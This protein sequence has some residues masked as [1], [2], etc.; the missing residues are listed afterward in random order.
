M[1][2]SLINVSDNYNELSFNIIKNLYN[3]K[4]IIII[5]DDNDIDIYRYQLLIHSC[6]FS[7]NNLYNIINEYQYNNILICICNININNLIELL[8]FNNDDYENNNIDLV[9][10]ININNLHNLNF[11]ENNKYHK[12][13]KHIIRLLYG[14]NYYITSYNCNSDFINKFG[15]KLYKKIKNICIYN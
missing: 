13:Y 1:N 2:K 10:F 3:N 6:N 5:I 11:I 4:N 9:Y 15:F 12:Y 7:F 14:I 8:N